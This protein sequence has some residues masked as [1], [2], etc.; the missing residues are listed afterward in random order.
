MPWTYP[1]DTTHSTLPP[2][3]LD[4][5]WQRPRAYF[6]D[7]D[8]WNTQALAALGYTWEEPAPVV[9]TLEQAKARKTE[10]IRDAAEAFLAPY[11]AEYGA[12]EVAT[13]DQQYAEAQ[14]G[15]GPLLSAIATARGMAVADLAGRILA[16]RVA[17]VTLAGS[18]VG[19]R[20]GY[21]D[22]VDAAET[23]EAVQAVEPV[24]SLPGV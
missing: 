10:Q 6:R 7:G 12:T 17:W 9:V 3:I 20:L 15:E 24:F 22:A 14:A 18:V 11:R 4:G 2:V 8:G 5:V 19:Q 13:W 21:Q 16:N 23:V 1:D